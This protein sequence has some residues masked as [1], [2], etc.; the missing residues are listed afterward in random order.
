A[1]KAEETNKV[2]TEEAPAAE[3]T[4]K[5]ATE[6]TPA[7]ED[8]NAK[9]NSNAQ[10]SETERTQVVDTVLKIYIKNLKLQKQKKLKLKKYYQ[11]IFQTYLMKKLKK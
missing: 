3:E 6:E 10:P 1:P 8:T 11:K 9:S 7:V 5:A 4:N 2:E